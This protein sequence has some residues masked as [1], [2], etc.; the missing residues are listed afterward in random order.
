MVSAPVVV[1]IALFYVHT[2][3]SPTCQREERVEDREEKPQRNCGLGPSCGGSGT[4]RAAESRASVPAAG[5]GEC[6]NSDV[7]EPNSLFSHFKLA[8]I[9][10]K[11]V[12]LVKEV[13]ST[14]RTNQTF[15]NLKRNGL[16]P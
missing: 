1:F 7:I 14:F 6:S 12:P 8:S 10:E 16:G 2:S 4:V 3:S 13:A 9:I 15:C 5:K 11:D